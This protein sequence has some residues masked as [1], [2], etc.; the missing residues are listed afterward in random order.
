MKEVRQPGV[1]SPETAGAACLLP[2]P[3]ETGRILVVD[4][5]EPVRIVISR[6]VAKLGFAADLAPDG[7]QALSVF[8]ANPGL[9]AA[10]LVDVK[11][12]G[13][14]SGVDVVRELRLLRP[15]LP[16]VLTSGYSLGAAMIESFVRVDSVGF[17]QKPFKLESLAAAL[18]TA[19][20]GQFRRDSM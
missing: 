18:H 7:A 15:E 12:P 2:G 17:L 14:M 1:A 8:A 5:S 4:D 3:S 19:L 9:Y 13:G 16:A 11:L 20:D 6:A 10:A